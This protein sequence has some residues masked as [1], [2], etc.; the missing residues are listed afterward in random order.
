MG[1]IRNKFKEFGGDGIYACWKLTYDEPYFKNLILRQ[2]NIISKKSSQILKTPVQPQK[3]Q[4]RLFQ[5]KT[6]YWDFS[7]AEKQADILHKTLTYFK[8]L[9]QLKIIVKNKD[10]KI[11]FDLNNPPNLG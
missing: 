7:I 10:F 6:N 11:K 8:N 2:R 5:F 9:F 3:I 1:K 4:P